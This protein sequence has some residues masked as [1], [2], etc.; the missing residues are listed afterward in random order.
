VTSLPSIPWGGSKNV[1]RL[2]ADAMK[3]KCV[4]PVVVVMVAELARF[5]ADSVVWWSRDVVLHVSA[6]SSGRSESPTLKASCPRSS[7]CLQR[8]DLQKVRTRTQASCQSLGMAGV[9]CRVPVG[10]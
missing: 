8:A 2:F 6:Q 1:E 3:K 7:W 4:F 5:N 10:R 9:C